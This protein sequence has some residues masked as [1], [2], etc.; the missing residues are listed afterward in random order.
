[1]NKKISFAMM[2][3]M[4][5]MST[6]L[7]AVLPTRAYTWHCSTTSWDRGG[8]SATDPNRDTNFDL[9]TG[10]LKE[11]A[12]N[13]DEANAWINSASIDASADVSTIRVTI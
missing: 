13:Y 6:S 8:K 11:L 3:I 7:F 2:V 9:T 5:I 1:M 12:V 4:I 10:E